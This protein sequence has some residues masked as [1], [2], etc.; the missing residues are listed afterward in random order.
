MNEVI[1][2]Q[3]FEQHG[4]QFS[5]HQNVLTRAWKDSLYL[6]KSTEQRF[7]GVSSWESWSRYD[8][9]YPNEMNVIYAIAGR[10]YIETGQHHSLLLGRTAWNTLAAVNN[11]E[12]SVTDPE[13]IL[14]WTNHIHPD[15]RNGALRRERAAAR[16]AAAYAEL[17]SMAL[18]QY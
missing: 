1:T 18:S 9:E 5:R 10:R 12:L 2:K 4:Q 7:T 14:P 16:L 6:A 13:Y 8:P 3:Q 11:D 15:F 17:G